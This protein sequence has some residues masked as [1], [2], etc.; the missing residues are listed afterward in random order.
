VLVDLMLLYVASAFALFG[1]SAIRSAPVNHWL[2]AAFPVLVVAIMI[3]RNPRDDR[4]KGSLFA[5]FT[6]VVAAVARASVLTIALAAMLGAPHSVNL[7]LRLGSIATAFLL[8][9]RG[10]LLFARRHARRTPAHA[11]PTL[12]IGAGLVGDRLAQRLLADRDYGMR[13]VGFL[14][15][16]P[17]PTLSS[18]DGP[19][20]PVL[21][22]PADLASAV[23]QTGARHV[24]LAFSAEPDRV[25]LRRVQECEAL[26]LSVSLVPRLFEAINDRATLDHVAGMP[27]VTLR[28]ISP[29]GWQFAVKHAFDRTV[30]LGGLIVL[31]PVML[32]VALAVRLGSPG[33]ILFRQRRVGRDGREF[34]VLKFRTMKLAQSAPQRIELVD[35]MAPGGIEGVDRRTRLGRFLRDSSLDELPQLLNVLRGDMSL[36]GP[37]PERPEFTVKFS[38]DIIRYDERHRVKSGITGWAQAHGLRGQTS[39]ADRVE[40]DNYYIQN[41]SLG[42]DLRI[43][44]LTLIEVLRRHRDI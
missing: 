17:L 23:R 20:V 9:E 19:A 1:V 16:D 7:G 32:G 12:I 34:D 22:S 18:G 30:A 6:A 14:D 42:L 36:I 29:R 43:L 41:W 25:M 28:A 27:M 15:S 11:T 10:A 39:I 38:Q 4:F 44:G 40:W 33:P 3:R 2:T 8:L 5:T 21:G 35:G 24:I 13:P 26:G 31:A 37:R